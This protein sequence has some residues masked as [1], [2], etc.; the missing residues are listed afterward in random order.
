M[1]VPDTVASLRAEQVKLTARLAVIDAVLAGLDELFGDETTVG[2]TPAP[3]RL[4]K[5]K[6]RPSAATYV[7]DRCGRSFNRPNGLSR[8]LN[9][10]HDAKRPTLKLTPDPLDTS[11][12][13]RCGQCGWETALSDDATDELV[14]HCLAEHSR[15][16]RDRERQPR[17]PRP[18]PSVLA[19]GDPQ[20]ELEAAT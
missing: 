3:R 10:S 6:A 15:S 13:L 20:A 17:A 12:V 19:N 7:C 4:A 5:R 2:D 9:Q 14:V 11:L 1:S 18:F 8:H 16:P